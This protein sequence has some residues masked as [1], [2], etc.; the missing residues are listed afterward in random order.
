LATWALDQSH[1]QGPIGGIIDQTLNGSTNPFP[2]GVALQ[3]WLSGVGALGQ[4]GV[5]GTELS[6]YSPRYNATV[7]ATNT[8]SQPWIT[9]DSSGQ[10]GATMYF[11]LY[12][13]VM[14]APPPPDSTA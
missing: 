9:S 12:T 7:G 5:P 13:T 3:K 8:P 11:S 6:I 14:T 2:K 4:G 1:D 10:Q